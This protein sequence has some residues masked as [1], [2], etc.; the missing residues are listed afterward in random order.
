MMI[1]P[2]VYADELKNEPF[3]K[4]V[5][6]RERLYKELKKIEKDAF[7]SERMMHGIYVRVRMC[8]TRCI[9]NIWLNFVILLRRNTGLRLCGESRWKIKRAHLRR[10]SSKHLP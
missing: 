8:S 6:E 9:W 5:K 10:V 1:S 3:E 7:D 2:Q 4:L